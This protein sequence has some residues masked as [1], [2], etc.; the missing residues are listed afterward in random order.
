MSNWSGLI[1]RVLTK[2]AEQAKRTIQFNIRDNM[3][4]QSPY[5]APLAEST[6]RAKNGS[7]KALVDKNKFYPGI[8]T[9]VSSKEAIVYS[10]GRPAEIQRYFLFGTK[11]IP[12]R[13]AFRKD[14]TSLGKRFFAREPG[15]VTSGLTFKKTGEQNDLES[16]L[17]TIAAAMIYNEA[18]KEIHKATSKFK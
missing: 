6:I 3:F 18:N 14:Q 4:G 2:C 9:K 10:D 1:K 7:D 15:G 8:K 17:V 5:G 13:N 16:H 11:T 12:E